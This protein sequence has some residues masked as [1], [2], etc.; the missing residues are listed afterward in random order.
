[1]KHLASSLAHSYHPFQMN[2]IDHTMQRQILTH[3]CAT[4]QFPRMNPQWKGLDEPTHKRIWI[5]VH[6]V[7]LFQARFPKRVSWT[8]AYR[9]Q[10]GCYRT[11]RKITAL[12]EMEGVQWK[13]SRVSLTQ[14]ASKMTFHSPLSFL[15]SD[16][17]KGHVP[18]LMLNLLGRD[19]CVNV[20]VLCN[21]L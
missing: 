12:D 5:A 6:L 3:A 4:S 20:G 19:L 1:M 10:S 8:V 17:K 18:S 7:P 21:R 11:V 14:E 2:N 15:N 16:L 9:D 13:W